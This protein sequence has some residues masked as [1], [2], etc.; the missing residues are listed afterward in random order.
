MRRCRES[1]LTN[2]GNQQAKG[3]VEAK[4]PIAIAVLSESAFT[5]QK[6]L[7]D[8]ESTCTREEAWVL[9]GVL[10]GLLL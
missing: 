5:C 1:R 7:S 9:T 10:T 8:I 3:T 2:G 4:L 6:S